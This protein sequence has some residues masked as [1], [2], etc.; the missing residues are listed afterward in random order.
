MAMATSTALAIGAIAGKVGSAAIASRSGGKAADKAAAAQLE[1]N[2]LAVEESRRQEEAKIAWDRE[3]WARE[4][5][6]W[7]LIQQQ[8]FPRTQAW[9]AVAGHHISGLDLP[10]QAPQLALGG[11]PPGSAAALTSAPSG[12]LGALATQG[13]DPRYAAVARTAPLT[14][15][16]VAPRYKTLGELANWGRA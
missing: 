10:T 12:S 14:D 5:E 11:A 15:P 9:G 1:A 2:R 7:N 13:I 16:L 6:M 8:N 4:G 3:Q